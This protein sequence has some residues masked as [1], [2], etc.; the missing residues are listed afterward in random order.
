MRF[1]LATLFVLTTCGCGGPYMN[2]RQPIYLVPREN[3]WSGCESDPDGYKACQSLRVKQVNIGINAWL[4]Y[5]DKHSR[6]VVI[7]VASNQ[8]VP[9]YTVN[10]P[11]YLGIDK[12]YCEEVFDGRKCEACYRYS[13]YRN[14]EIIFSSAENIAT[15]MDHEFGHVLGRDDNDVPKGTTS[16]M[17]YSHPGA[18]SPLDFAMMCRLHRECT[19]VVKRQP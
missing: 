10:E 9:F 4:N 7:V 5:F 2:L 11:I 17:S 13:W 19:V 16:V 1:I 18:V 14:T 15:A 6:P 8:D 3:F 12:D